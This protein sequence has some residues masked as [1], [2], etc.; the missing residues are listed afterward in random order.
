MHIHRGGAAGVRQVRWPIELPHNLLLHSQ[1]LTTTWINGNTTETTNTT[2]APD[3]TTT[4]D[5]L[6][7]NGTAAA[8]IRQVFTTVSGQPYTFSVHLKAGTVDWAVIELTDFI[9]D[10]AHAWF[11]LTDGAVGT[12][13]TAGTWTHTVPATII[14]IGDGWFR[15]TVTTTVNVTSTSAGIYLSNADLNVDVAN[16]DTIIV[17]GGQVNNGTRATNYIATT[18]SPIT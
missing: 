12:S 15:C 18:S 9:N 10:G 14:D 16:N 8:H 4:A 6:T 17:W 13:A 7:S 2:V 3:G 11:D 5:T 1:D